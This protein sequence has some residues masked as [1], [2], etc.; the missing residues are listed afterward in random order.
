MGFIQ[1]LDKIA[2]GIVD[3][4]A[5][6]SPSTVYGEYVEST[7]SE[8]PSYYSKEYGYVN[9]NNVKKITKS[10]R[11]Q[12]QEVQAKHLQEI[13]NKKAQQKV[14]WEQ[15]DKERIESEKKY[16]EQV[17][18]KWEA[19]EKEKM[20]TPLY[21]LISKLSKNP[22]LSEKTESELISYIAENI[23]AYSQINKLISLMPELE[24]Y[25]KEFMPNYRNDEN[26]FWT[27]ISNDE[28]LLKQLEEIKRIGKIEKVKTPVELKYEASKQ[29]KSAKINFLELYKIK[30]LPQ[31]IIDATSK[32]YSPYSFFNDIKKEEVISWENK[33]VAEKLYNL[34]QVYEQLEKILKKAPEFEGHKKEIMPL[35]NQSTED[36]LNNLKNN[37]AIIG[38][39]INLISLDKKIENAKQN[40]L[41]NT[42]RQINENIER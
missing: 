32:M 28:D 9:A 37:K 26:K 4:I 19:E 6:I 18:L 2:P 31:E 27:E 1:N 20:K 5:S 33:L 35:Y 36:F 24:K 22:E 7:G 17:L 34:L 42:Q 14:L 16:K 41:D 39:I 40:N 3:L 29:D 38:E 23:V 30:N 13:E 10:D 8:P 21:I 15:Q 25:I 12:L 11:K